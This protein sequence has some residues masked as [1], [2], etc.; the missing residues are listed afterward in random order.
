[1]AFI[2]NWR[3]GINKIF[4]L[5][6]F[7]MNL[8]SLIF[9][10]IYL[11]KG[12]GSLIWNVYGVIF[13]LTLFG[14]ILL[15]T[16]EERKT[17]L[18]RVYLFLSFLF[19]LS[20]ALLNTLVSCLPANYRSQSTLSEIL[21][22]A[23]IIFGGALAAESLRS[24]RWS[25]SN[26]GNAMISTTTTGNHATSMHGSIPQTVFIIILSAVLYFGLFL[27]INMLRVHKTG[28]RPADME[29][30]MDIG[31]SPLKNAA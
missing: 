24:D 22:F 23:L 6:I 11:S 13:L 17:G 12:E 25:K 4:V 21:W 30:G 9:G 5:G 29:S 31:L 16:L 20:A 27:A 1:M 14:N 7:L 19:P 2:K 10:L 8:L 18:S 3:E 28:C 26:V 15:A